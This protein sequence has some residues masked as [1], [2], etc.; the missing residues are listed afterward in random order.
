[1]DYYRRTRT[2]FKRPCVC[3]DTM[4]KSNDFTL[5]QGH[6]YRTCQVAAAFLYLVPPLIES[7]IVDARS[8][9]EQSLDS[10]KCLPEV[11]PPKPS[12]L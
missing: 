7:Q 1:M 8:Q 6:R 5:A 12:K 11:C 10:S 3:L 9:Q 2:S 4:Q